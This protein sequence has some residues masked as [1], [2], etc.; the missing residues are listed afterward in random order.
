MKNRVIAL[1]ML[2]PIVLMFCVFSAANFTSLQVPIAVSGISLYHERLE[3]VNLAESEEFKINAQVMPINASN[4]GLIYSYEAVDGKNV[5]NITIN[6]NGVVSASGCGTA[7]VV[8]TT[9]DGAYKKS[10]FL[11]VTST[12]AIELVATLSTESE[13]LVGD[14]FEILTEVLPDA[15]LDKNVEFSSSDNNIILVDSITGKCKAISS[16]RAKPSYVTAAIITARKVYINAI[17]GLNLTNK[18]FQS[19]NTKTSQASDASIETT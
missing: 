18:L 9:K 11:E 10:F 7:K 13:I 2:I 6:D 3:V 15:A 19:I 5:P 12:K 16:G 14:E 8:V 17:V 4:K 1:I